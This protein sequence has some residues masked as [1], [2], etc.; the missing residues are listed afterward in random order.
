ME[1]PIK[2][3]VT[4]FWPVAMDMVAGFIANVRMKC[5]VLLLGGGCYKVGKGIIA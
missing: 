5:S 2:S 3:K 1:L 4:L